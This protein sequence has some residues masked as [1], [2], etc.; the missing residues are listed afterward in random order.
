VVTALASV[1][2]FPLSVPTVATN[3]R[4]GRKSVNTTAVRRL[5]SGVKR[6]LETSCV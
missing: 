2:K 4:K 3:L 1:Q 6:T 5:K